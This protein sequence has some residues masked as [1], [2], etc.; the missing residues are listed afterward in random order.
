MARA[1]YPD[2]L[3]QLIVDLGEQVDVDVVGFEGVAVLAETD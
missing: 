3:Q 2:V 1:R